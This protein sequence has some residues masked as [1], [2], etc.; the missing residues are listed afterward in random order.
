VEGE[1]KVESGKTSTVVLKPETGRLKAK[2]VSEEGPVSDQIRVS[3]FVAGLF[4]G[5]QNFAENMSRAHQSSP[6][7]GA[8][9][10]Q[11]LKPGRYDLM[12][13]DV[14]MGQFAPHMVRNIEIG[15]GTTD[16]GEIKIPRSDQLS[17]V[18]QDASGQAV[19]G[20]GVGFRLMGG[21]YVPNISRTSMS[22]HDGKITVSVP[23][24]TQS[25][26]IGAP[27]QALK[28][29]ALPSPGQIVTVTAGGQIEVQ[30]VGG[31]VEGWALTLLKGNGQALPFIF[32]KSFMGGVKVG[33]FTDA[34]GK[35][36]IK[37]VPPGEVMVRLSKHGQEALVSEK[38]FVGE[39]QQVV[40]SLTGK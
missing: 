27:G 28:E 14:M 4:S 12:V 3:L 10:I 5:D 22:G 30:V 33:A 15:A 29:T 24:Q 31:E 18:I 11:G 8:V 35:A 26:L 23:K 1:V 25:I 38:V 32:D 13:A 36:T 21:E 40:V 17:F 34:S 9:D 2:L 20:A 16:L 37:N 6:E 7:M 19:Q 39:G